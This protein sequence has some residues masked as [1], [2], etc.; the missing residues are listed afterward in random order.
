MSNVSS[1]TAAEFASQKQDL[2]ESGRWHELHDGQPVL[3]S[4]PDDTHGTIV[5]NLTRALAVW[6]QTQPVASR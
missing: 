1:I 4:A 3:L 6:F 2:P 5:L